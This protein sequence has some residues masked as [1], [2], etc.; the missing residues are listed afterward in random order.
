MRNSCQSKGLE[1]NKDTRGAVM[2]KKR[3][4]NKKKQKAG[5]E[6]GSVQKKRGMLVYVPAFC[7]LIGTLMLLTVIAAALPLTVPQF[8]GYDIYNVVSGSM[9]PAIPIGSIIYVKPVDPE[10][11]KVGEIIVFEAGDSV[12]M[13]RVRENNVV[14]GN[15]TTKGDANNVEDLSK[16]SYSDFVGIVARHIPVLGQLLI[17][18]ESTVGRICMICFA[19]CGALLNVLSAR[20]SEYLKSEKEY[21]RRREELLARAMKEKEGQEEENAGGNP[22]GQDRKEQGPAQGDPAVQEQTEQ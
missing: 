18:F 15:F 21:E 10:D 13:H 4:Q 14:S 9:E 11:V 19:A 5:A 20:F 1:D 12:V 6:T 22:T 2:A 3:S 7:S 17:L 8:M 16:V